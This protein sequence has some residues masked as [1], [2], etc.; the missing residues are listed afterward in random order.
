MCLGYGNSHR[1]GKDFRR[2]FP[3]LAVTVVSLSL[4]AALIAIVFSG[5]SSRVNKPVE[6]LPM[7][8][9]LLPPPGIDTKPTPL[10]IV[11]AEPVKEKKIPKP[12]PVV[13]PAPQ[14]A[15][16]P[17]APAVAPRSQVTQEIKVPDASFEPRSAPSATSALPSPAAPVAAPPVKTGVS[18]PASYAASN[19]KPAYPSRS[20]KLEEE[21]TVM[22]RVLVKDDGTAGT[23]EIKSSSG[24]PLLDESAKTA[25]QTWRFNPAT[26]DGKPVSEWFLV[27][28]PFKLQ[29]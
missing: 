21:G 25:V 23:V 29:S 17:V 19:R 2:V 18:I 15:V 4:H 12:R 10:P 24:Y 9:N 11:S 26:S 8:V 5:L 7:T 14:P 3:A 6:L 13:K 28:I 27:P 16:K 22:L 1:A 20:R